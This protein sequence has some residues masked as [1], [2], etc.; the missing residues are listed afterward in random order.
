M[1]VRTNMRKVSI[2]WQ[3][4]NLK[5][6]CWWA[7]TDWSAWGTCEESCGFSTQERTRGCAGA[8]EIQ[9]IGEFGGSVFETRECRLRICPEETC[10]D[11]PGWKDKFNQTCDDYLVSYCPLAEVMVE[12]NA[13]DANMACCK[14]LELHTTFHPTTSPTDFPSP[15]P[16]ESPLTSKCFDFNGFEDSGGDGCEFY[17]AKQYCSNG[18]V[19]TQDVDSFQI[20]R[21]VDGLTALDAC[22]ACGGGNSNFKKFELRMKCKYTLML[23]VGISSKVLSFL[24]L[25]DI[26]NKWPWRA[27]FGRKNFIFFI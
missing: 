9:C 19:L 3:M 12:L 17:E 22:C 27:A 25:F 13:L 11:Y 15:S 1:I 4:K 21:N 26:W 5:L 14:C 8:P 2:F 18:N 7:W 24:A 6:L 16:T 20:W 10:I 23:T